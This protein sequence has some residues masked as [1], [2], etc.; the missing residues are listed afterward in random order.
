MSYE[1]KQRVTETE[2]EGKEEEKMSG[3]N[4]LVR[5][6]IGTNQSPGLHGFKCLHGLRGCWSSTEGTV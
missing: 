2:K 3:L 4:S 5:V 1:H 6:L